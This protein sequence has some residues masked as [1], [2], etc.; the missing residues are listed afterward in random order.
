MAVRSLIAGITLAALGSAAAAADLAT[1]N[2]PA[3]PA[4]PAPQT[5]PSLALDPQAPPPSIWKGLYVGTDLFFSGG[6]HQKGLVGGGGFVGYDRRFDDNLVIGVEASTGFAPFSLQHGPF[7]GYD[8]AEVSG[9]VGYEMGR[10][11][12][13]LTAGIALAR[14]NGAPGAGY[15]S[16]TDSANA[17][18]NGGG[19]VGGSG[20]F[21]AGFDYALTGNTTIGVAAV[22][23]TG[24]G[25]VAPP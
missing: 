24:R 11:T 10:V 18:F 15:L 19:G 25:F 8:Y 2:L 3:A 6:R 12:P 16:P 5:L 22:V 14:P 7:R 9:K 4:A 20:V 23:G 13:Y 17:V 1:P 21:G